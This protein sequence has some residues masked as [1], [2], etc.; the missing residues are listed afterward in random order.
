MQL[1]PEMLGDRAQ[2]TTQRDEHRHQV[3][4]RQ[5]QHR[6]E[7]ELRRDR[8]SKG[9]L[10][11]HARRE[12]IAGDERDN[13]PEACVRPRSGQPDE[14]CYRGRDERSSGGDRGEDLAATE[15]A[16]DAGT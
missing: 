15:P 8:V 4:R 9:D 7:D 10:E 5:E 1:A 6:N 14:Q 11:L 12:R 16:R 2:N 13:D 3:E